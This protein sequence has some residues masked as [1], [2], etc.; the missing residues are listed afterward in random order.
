MLFG[1]DLQEFVKG[2]PSKKLYLET[3]SYDKLEKI[4]Q[5]WMLVLEIL[6]YYMGLMKLDLYIKSLANATHRSYKGG[7]SHF[8]TFFINN[9]KPL[10]DWF[11]EDDCI[12]VF[13]DFITWSSITTLQVLILK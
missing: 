10:P 12:I 6:C 13:E 8:I 3:K 11:D 1:K 2:Y 7:W 9:N 5:K 4:P